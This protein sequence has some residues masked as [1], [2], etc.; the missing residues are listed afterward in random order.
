MIAITS[1]LPTPMQHGVAHSA[2]Y[3]ADVLFAWS[4]TSVLTA[5]PARRPPGRVSSRPHL[6]KPAARRHPGRDSA[7]HTW[8]LA[9]AAYRFA[10][11]GQALETGRVL[12]LLLRHD[13]PIQTRRVGS[14]PQRPPGDPPGR[15]TRCHRDAR[16]AT[17]SVRGG[18][19]DGFVHAVF[20]DP[21][22][23]LIQVPR[24]T[25]HRELA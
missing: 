11:A 19:A 13:L 24:W 12:A 10:S 4:A 8:H 21:Q 5:L 3:A 18:R 22:P 9:L 25:L 2:S 20:A 16:P 15:D 23:R 7:E 14:R 17:Q 1:A 6:V